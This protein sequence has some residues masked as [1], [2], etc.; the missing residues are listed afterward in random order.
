MT[1]KEF[2]W[3]GIRFFGVIYLIKSI[4]I[5]L[6]FFTAAAP[7]GMMFIHPQ[8]ASGIIARWSILGSLLEGLPS[9][10]LC[11]YLLFF[12][13]WAFNIIAR[14]S[15][16]TADD[17]LQKENDT[18]ILIRFLGLRWICGIFL[19]IIGVISRLF[20]LGLI[21]V[22]PTLTEITEIAKQHGLGD[23]VKTIRNPLT[24]QELGSIAFSLLISAL[25]AWYFLGYGKFFINLLNR[26]WLKA[27]GTNTNQNPVNPV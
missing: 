7:L 10:L 27:S 9:I 16:L 1:K 14:T 6:R 5:L 24:H 2:I 26:L 4:G 15:Q 22:S 12:G 20:M 23:P 13:K 25:L 11:L 19:Q 21:K 8:G 3:L 18:E 17:L